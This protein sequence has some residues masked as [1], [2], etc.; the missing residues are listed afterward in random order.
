MATLMNT[1]SQAQFP[2]TDFRKNSRQI[3]RFLDLLDTGGTTAISTTATELPQAVVHILLL[4]TVEIV[5]IRMRDSSC[6][7]FASTWT[8]CDETENQATLRFK[9]FFPLKAVR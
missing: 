4:I 1:M 7:N 6:H 9:M 5:M 8:N 2:N 3:R